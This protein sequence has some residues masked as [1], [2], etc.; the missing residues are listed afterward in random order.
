M[1]IGEFLSNFY[2][3]LEK[4]LIHINLNPTQPELRIIMKKLKVK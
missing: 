2:L 4:T 3:V 1:C